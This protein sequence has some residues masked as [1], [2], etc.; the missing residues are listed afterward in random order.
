M[1]KVREGAHVPF[2]ITTDFGWIFG[3]PCICFVPKFWSLN[4]STWIGCTNNVS[5][6]VVWFFLYSRVSRCWRRLSSLH[7]KELNRYNLIVSSCFSAF[8][9][10]VWNWKERNVFIFLY[11][12]WWSVKSI[13]SRDACIYVFVMRFNFTFGVSRTLR[14]VLMSRV[15]GDDVFF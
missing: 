7:S 1:S 4:N 15:D 14:S 10:L 2:L 12:W 13:S 8:V 3:K 5:L 9:E 11:N 6:I